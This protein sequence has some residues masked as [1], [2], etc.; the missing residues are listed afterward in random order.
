VENNLRKEKIFKRIGKESDENEKIFKRIG[1]QSEENENFQ[2]NWELENSRK[3]MKNFKR[4]RKG[5]QSDENEN[6][7]TD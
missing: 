1:K 3:R 7:Q 5:K 2:T 4:D 6:F